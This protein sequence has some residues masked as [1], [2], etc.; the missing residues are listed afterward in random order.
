MKLLTFKTGGGNYQR[1]CIY[2][3]TELSAFCSLIELLDLIRDNCK[4]IY[5]KA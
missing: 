1:P 3:V 5:M 4:A 2:R